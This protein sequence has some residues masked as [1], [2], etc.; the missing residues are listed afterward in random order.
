MLAA[1]VSLQVR[2]TGHTNVGRSSKKPVRFDA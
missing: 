1:W 2:L